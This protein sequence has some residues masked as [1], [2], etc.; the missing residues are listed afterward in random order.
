MWSSGP[1]IIID[2]RPFWPCGH[3]AK[4]PRFDCPEVTTS[5]KFCHREENGIYH[6][7]CAVKS[8]SCNMICHV[9]HQPT[10]S[11][12]L[13]RLQAKIYPQSV[14]RGAPYACCP[15]APVV[16]EG[17]FGAAAPLS[18]QLRRTG[19][20]LQEDR[21]SAV[22][23]NLKQHLDLDKPSGLDS[24]KLETAEVV[25]GKISLGLLFLLCSSNNPRSRTAPNG[26]LNADANACQLVSHSNAHQ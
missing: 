10:S 3:T 8:Q 25:G 2:S 13:S 26:R 4:G 16:L 21:K 18:T 23:Q 1:A 14:T 9:L 19:A 17:T 15:T 20:T 24:H 6:L 22:A 12:A 7:K 11:A 5:R